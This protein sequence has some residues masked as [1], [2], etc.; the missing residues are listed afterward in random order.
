[1]S[2]DSHKSGSGT[3]HPITEQIIDVKDLIPPEGERD[4][5][6]TR[7]T[8]H[9]ETLQSRFQRG[10]INTLIFTVDEH[11]IVDGNYRR[12]VM[13]ELAESN[14]DPSFRNVEVL[15]T[16]DGYAYAVPVNDIKID[17]ET[18]SVELNL[19]R[20]NTSQADC[21]KFLRYL[22]E[23][24]ILNPE[25]Y[26]VAGD[27]T[28]TQLL[29]QLQHT[30]SRGDEWPHSEE[31]RKLL[32]R[33]IHDLDFGSPKSARTYV[34]QLQRA[35][36]SVKQAWAQEQLGRTHVEELNEIK[37]YAN[38]STFDEYVERTRAGEL[39][40]DELREL[41]QK[42]K[43]SKEPPKG[44][45]PETEDEPKEG[46]DLSDEQK[47]QAA[48]IVEHRPLSRDEYIQSL[49]EADD[50]AKRLDEDEAELKE[51]IEENSR[52]PLGARMQ[53]R[54]EAIN[55]FDF[56]SES[57]FAT[58]SADHLAPPVETDNLGVFFHNCNQMGDELDDES[59]QLVF[60][61][62]PY[63]TQ[64]GRIIDEWWPTDAEKTQ[65]NADTA[66]ET[67]LSAMMEVFEKCY[68][69][70]VEGGY[71]ALNISDY[72]IK[73]LAKVYDIPSDFS[74]RLRHTEELTFNYIST[75]TWDKDS[76]TGSRLANF[77][78]SNNIADFRPAW[79][80]ERILLFRKDGK[81]EKQDYTVDRTALNAGEIDP[82]T[83]VWNVS[84]T[85]GR[86]AAHES[87]F[88]VELPKLA[89]RLFT[90]PGDT[91]ID[92]FGGFATTLRAVKQVNKDTTD[93]PPRKGFAWEN[94]ASEADDQVDYRQQIQ[95][96]L[97]AL[98]SFMK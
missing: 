61:S 96:Q 65:S 66:Y 83:D 67:Y 77:R 21:A 69:K 32:L 25:R 52:K 64:R 26:G 46:P 98:G 30:E 5:R 1:M 89:V 29:G 58:G 18:A 70:L 6:I 94:F 93:A 38:D 36:K 53:E 95:S 3:E 87:G 35:P 79:R 13:I 11:F 88:P 14:N 45:P 68:D 81:R 97:G 40:R 55:D 44:N 59:V 62:P 22:I 33:F 78:S 47:Q 15:G 41:K 56:D 27:T 76:E 72:K 7:D 73:G 2:S 57:K 20:Q 9:I 51:L 23:N 82:F 80:T 19:Y 17:P 34:E 12:E 50:V 10:L 54:Q 4:P 42:L 71:L 90:Y 28:P 84:P 31:V 48:F 91:V 60:T 16:K 85:T 75:I 74:Y 39:T 24:R 49:S 92:P 86:D 37:K 63:F 43:P 8:E